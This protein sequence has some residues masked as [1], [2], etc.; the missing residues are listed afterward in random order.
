VLTPALVALKKVS[1]RRAMFMGMSTNHPTLLVVD[2]EYGA[3]L[4][5]L[6][7]KMM[8]YA[9]HFKGPVPPADA[10]RDVMKVAYE[11]SLEK[12]DGGTFVSH[13]GTKRWL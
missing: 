1:Q 10:V 12:G 8:I 4:Q 13:L 9:P 11:A 5:A 2:E 6:F 7:A 3:K